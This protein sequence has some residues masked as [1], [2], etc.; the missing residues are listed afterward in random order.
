MLAK[1]CRGY[2]VAQR[3]TVR[4]ICDH[5]IVRIR[6]LDDSGHQRDVFAA[7]S[8]RVASPVPTL[9]VMLRPDAQLRREVKVGSQERAQAGMLMQ[10]E[11]LRRRGLS[12][13]IQH[14]FRDEN[15]PTS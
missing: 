9:V 1:L 2:I 13:P 4:A 8:M 15:L 11:K 3:F 5:C 12:W 10:N 7:K 14:S 6:H